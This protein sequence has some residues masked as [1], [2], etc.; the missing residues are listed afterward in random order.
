MRCFQRF[1]EDVC[2]LVFG[3]QILQADNTILDELW[4]E[5]HVN[6]NVF[7][8]FMLQWVAINVYGTLIITP[9]NSRMIVLNAKLCH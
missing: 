6:L 8:P 1:S 9:N 2:N 3:R 4:N 7:F 5:V